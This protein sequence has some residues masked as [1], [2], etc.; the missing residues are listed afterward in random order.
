MGMKK[1]ELYMFNTTSPNVYNKANYTWDP[2]SEDSEN[3][4]ILHG[5]FRIPNKNVGRRSVE[6]QFSVFDM[7]AKGGD[8]AEKF[9]TD[10]KIARSKLK[11]NFMITSSYTDYK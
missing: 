2:P 6:L 10:L 8:K 11:P 7:T 3:P 5:S 9:V 4:G 1:N